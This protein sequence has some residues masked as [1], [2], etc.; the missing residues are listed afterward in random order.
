MKSLNSLEELKDYVANN[1]FVLVYFSHDKCN[2][3]KVLK[4]SVIELIETEFPKVILLFADTLA[5]PEIAGQYG[6]FAVPTI[7]QFFDHR[8]IF[9]KSRNFGIDE[10][11]ELLEKPYSSVYSE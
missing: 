3:C 6:V 11:R 2:V 7:V 1:D 9:R 4:P 10:L 8:E 5:N